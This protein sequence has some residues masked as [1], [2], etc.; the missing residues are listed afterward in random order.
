MEFVGSC[1]VFAWAKNHH[2]HPHEFLQP[3]PILTSP[4]YSISMNFITDHPFSKSY[5]SILVMVGCL[6]K[7]VHFI[8]CNKTI[9][10]KKTI[11]LF[12]DHVFQYRGFFFKDIIFDRGPQFAS[13]FWKRFFDLF[14]MKMKLSSTFHPHMDGQMKHVNKV[15]EQYLCYTTNYHQ[16]NLV[17]PF[18]HG[19]FCLQRHSSFF[20]I[21]NIFFAN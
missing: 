3:L 20:N 4:W 11:K 5:D 10:S 13:K 17:K 7:M 1:D 14:N 2:P 9:I 16:D 8:P 19:I 21:I 18:I 6:T 15:L 12:F